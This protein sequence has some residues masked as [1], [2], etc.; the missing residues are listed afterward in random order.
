MP[1]D[2]EKSIEN[3]SGGSGFKLLV[4]D[5]HAV[6]S[7]KMEERLSFLGLAPHHSAIT[8]PILAYSVSGLLLI[9]LKWWM[10][11]GMPYPPEKMD[12][13]FQHLIMGNFRDA[14]GYPS[15]LP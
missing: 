7:K 12:E 4:K 11:K 10:D 1:F 6:L 2:T 9:L 14:L 8:L 3:W 5:G 15:S 13:I